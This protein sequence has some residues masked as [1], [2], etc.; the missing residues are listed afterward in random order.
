MSVVE[1]INLILKT[2]VPIALNGFPWI[3]AYCLA[4]FNS[5]TGGAFS[6]SYYDAHSELKIPFYPEDGLQKIREIHSERT[7]RK[8]FTDYY[9]ECQQASEP[10]NEATFIMDR[11][12]NIEHS[13]VMNYQ[14][15]FQ[16]KIDMIH[17]AASGLAERV[18]EHLSGVLPDDTVWEAGS[19][20]LTVREGKVA[21]SYSITIGGIPQTQPIKLEGW[22]RKMW[23][24]YYT[25]VKEGELKGH[26]PAWNTI[27]F[28]LPFEESDFYR[29]EQNIRYEVQ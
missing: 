9:I 4:T 25:L 14:R 22:E 23:L 26:F 5:A 21:F 20:M 3:K 29:D 10:W 13:F 2:E 6:V 16:R 8:L 19:A 15:V 17:T 28:K 18:Y 27:L 12:G 1:R 24:E 7:V 11:E